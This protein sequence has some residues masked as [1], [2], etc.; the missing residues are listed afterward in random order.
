MRRNKWWEL[1]DVNINKNQKTLQNFANL[2]STN[3]IKYKRLTSNIDQVPGLNKFKHSR[4]Q[5]LLVICFLHLIA[6]PNKCFLQ[7]DALAFA[8]SSDLSLDPGTN[9]YEDG[10]FNEPYRLTPIFPEEERGGQDID[11]SH[12]PLKRGTYNLQF[13]F[14][15]LP[16]QSD[17]L[18]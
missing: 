10:Y 12:D 2:G 8:S 1:A 7:C 9:L 6:S 14:L 18:L 13:R 5:N 15:G 17:V 3:R 11:K 4:C 16:F